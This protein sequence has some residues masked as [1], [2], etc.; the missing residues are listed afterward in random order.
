MPAT[1]RASGGDT[2]AAPAAKSGSQFNALTMVGYDTNGDGRVD[3]LD[4]NGDGN[5]DALVLPANGKKKT[6]LE[7]SNSMAIKISAAVM[8]A[9]QGYDTNGDGLIDHLD[10]NGDGKID[11]QIV[12]NAPAVHGGGGASQKRGHDGTLIA[13]GYDTNMDGRVDCLDTNGDGEIDAKVVALTSARQ[14]G[15][16]EDSKI[17]SKVLLSAAVTLSIVGYDTNGDGQIDHL[18]TNGDGK[19]DSQI[20]PYSEG[21]SDSDSPSAGAAAAPAP[22]PA[23]KASAGDASTKGSDG[24][25]HLPSS[26]PRMASKQDAK[27]E[28]NEFEP[29][30]K[31]FRRGKDAAAHPLAHD[32]RH[33]TLMLPVNGPGNA[34]ERMQVRISPPVTTPTTTC[35]YGQEGR[36]QQRR[37]AKTARGE[38]N[39]PTRDSLLL[40]VQPLRSEQPPNRVDSTGFWKVAWCVREGPVP[41]LCLADS[42]FS[43]LRR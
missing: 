29:S 18:D 11:S 33:V 36:R 41:R 2:R 19:I 25:V 37:R 40:S 34:S 20:V 23:S 42:R 28:P 12:P 16:P 13:V 27:V 3:S 8:L 7:T 43:A 9:V 6:Q 15:G 30:A 31:K 21:G 4:T 32:M 38:R 39:Q 5:I 22:A 14:G 1:K 10:T 26:T 24:A 35:L 17:A